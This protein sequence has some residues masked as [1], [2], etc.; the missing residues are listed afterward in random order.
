MPVGRKSRLKKARQQESLGKRYEAGEFEVP[1]DPSRIERR[2]QIATLAAF[3]AVVVTWGSVGSPGL[4]QSVAPLALIGGGF[5]A[6]ELRRRGRR[7]LAAAISGAA[8]IWFFIL[9]LVAPAQ[10]E[11]LAP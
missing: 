7:G 8:V 10:L 4:Q 1:P 9:L 5:A 6:A 2:G 3:L 11:V